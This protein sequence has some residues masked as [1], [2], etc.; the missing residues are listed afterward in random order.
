MD[1]LTLKVRPTEAE[2]YITTLS[3]FGWVLVNKIDLFDKVDLGPYTPKKFKSKTK[4]KV[5]MLNFERDNNAPN[6]K[7][8]KDAENKYLSV[9]EDG[10]KRPKSAPLLVGIIIL[11]ATVI[12]FL[13]F[14]GLSL[15]GAMGLRALANMASDKFLG[16][17]EFL[18]GAVSTFSQLL[19]FFGINLDLEGFLA[20]AGDI[21]D[22]IPRVVG[23]G[24]VIFFWAIDI[25]AAILPLIISIFLITLG[26]LILFIRIIKRAVA[27]NHNRHVRAVRKEVM[28]QLEFLEK[29]DNG[30]TEQTTITHAET[31][32]YQQPAQ[33][34]PVQETYAEPVEAEP[35]EAEAVA[36]PIEQ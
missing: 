25:I 9:T 14:G 4:C 20:G 15:L 19:N 27:N 24:S 5:S 31:T 32:Y 7:R 6:Y 11:V 36:E 30:V 13:V 29:R 10:T 26:I 28:D 23:V 21:A 12:G 2:K 17:A 3:K 22:Q 16:F 33:A 35:A 18:V 8:Y 34:A 1:T